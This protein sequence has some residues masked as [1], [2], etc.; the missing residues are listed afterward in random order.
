MDDHDKLCYSIQ[1]AEEYINETLEDCDP[2]N[3]IEF[4]IMRIKL[5]EIR[6]LADRI[7]ASIST[8]YLSQSSS[9]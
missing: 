1:L 2:G 6:E 9:K 7:H 4:N 8:P 5:K 3:S